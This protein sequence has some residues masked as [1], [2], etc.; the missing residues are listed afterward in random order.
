MG[1]TSK[2]TGKNLSL[3]LQRMAVGKGRRGPLGAGILTIDSTGQQHWQGRETAVPDEI[4]IQLIDQPE[5]QDAQKRWDMAQWLTEAL[6][7]WSD[8]HLTLNIV[9]HRGALLR[10]DRIGQLYPLAAKSHCWTVSVTTDGSDL[11]STAAIDQVL[12]SPIDQLHVRITRSGAERSS[13]RVLSAVKDLIDLRAARMQDRPEV[14]CRL[15]VAAADQSTIGQLRQWA[16]KIG[17]H[18]VV[19]AQE[20]IEESN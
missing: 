2:P 3:E 18:R 10:N 7:R 16:R 14:V 20:H 12:R 15:T 11:I 5:P 13:S 4:H 1:A 17:A 9:S 6:E 19:L 8:N